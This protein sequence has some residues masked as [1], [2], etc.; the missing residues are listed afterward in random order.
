MLRG[1]RDNSHLV[2]PNLGPPTL[3][4]PIGQGDELLRACFE[5]AF[6]SEDGYEAY[7][8]FV[9]T[10]WL[11]RV[12]AETKLLLGQGD[13]QRW[14]ALIDSPAQ[15]AELEKRVELRFLPSARTRYAAGDRV[16]LVVE[17]K[18]VPTLLV[19]VFAVDA[20]RYLIDKQKPVDATIE[21]D[22]IVANHEQSYRYEDPAMRRVARTFPLPMLDKAGTYVVEFVGNGISSRAVIHKGE[23]R[24]VETPGAAGHVLRV[25]DESG[26]HRTD[27][28][29]WFGGREYR[30]DERGEIVLP[31]STSPGMKKVVLR[32]GDH[33]GLANFQHQAESY[34]LVASVHTAREALLAG[35]KARVLVRPQLRLGDQ[36][37][38]L[39]LLVDP[40]LT[41]VATDHDGVAT[42][43]E[44]RDLKLV[45]ERELVHEIQVPERLAS[46]AVSLRG[47]VKDLAGKD[48]LLATAAVS[49][50][51]NRIDATAETG[52]ALLLPKGDGYVV[53]L[54]GK[55]GE[56]QG[57]RP[58]TVQVHLRDYREPATFFLQ[59]SADGR[60]ELGSLP[61]A[62]A[63]TIQRP[64]ATGGH[65]ELPRTR[66]RFP[67][68]L[69][70]LAGQV[71]RVPYDGSSTA[72]SRAEFSLLGSERDEFAHLAI[73]DGFVELRDLAPGDYE[74][75]LH[76][77][78]VR[79]P[80]R[81]IR[82]A[83]SGPWLLGGTRQLTV[84]DA[85]P[86]QVRASA[87]DAGLEV[88][89]ANATAATRV[90]VVGTRQLPTFDP[91][92]QLLGDAGRPPS[93]VQDEPT[94]SSYYSG[95][96]LSEEYRYVLERRL[97][98]KFFGNMLARPS[99]LANPW[100][101]QDSSNAPVGIG[102]GAGGA[103]GARGGRGRASGSPGK[104]GSEA[105]FGGNPG[106]FANLDWL[107]QGAIVLANLVPGADGIVRVP[108]QELGDG[109]F[110]QVVALDRDQAVTT[111]VVRAEQPLQP[112]ARQLPKA[113]DPQQHFAE[114]KRI[115]FVTAGGTAKL[116]D[117][118]QAQV[119]I[120][121]SLA[122]VFRLF[123]TISRDAE[124]AK[125]GFLM[126]WPTLD[127]AQK[128]KLYDEHACHELH[129]F[130]FHKDAQFFAAV[131]KPLL[132]NKLDKTFVDHWLL[133]S[134]LRG[135]L[136]PWTFAQLNLVERVLLSKRL[137]GAE[138]ATIA[139]SLQEELELR[140]VDRERAGRLLDLA[141]RAN[142]LQDQA[143]DGLTSA[144]LKAPAEEPAAPP[145][146]APAAPAPVAAGP[147]GP[148]TGGQP[149]AKPEG[150]PADGKAK[151]DT[152]KS[153]EE[154]RQRFAEAEKQAPP[155]Y[156]V[157]SLG[158][159]GGETGTIALAR[160]AQA[161]QLYRAVAATKL[162]VES[163]WWHR[164]LEQTTADVVAPN[165]FWVDYATAPAGQPFASPRSDRNQHQLPRDDDGARRAR[166]AVRRRQARSHQP[167]ATRAR[168]KA[169]TPLLLVRKEIRR[170]RRLPTSRRC[171]SARTSS[172]ST[173]ATASRTA[174][175]A[176]PSS[177]T[178][179]SSTSPTAARS[180]SPTRPRATAP[181]TCCCRSRPGA[182]PLQK[183]FW[184]KGHTVELAPYATADP[185]V[186][187][188]LPG[189][190]RLRPL[191]GPRRR[192][193]QAR[194]Q[195]RAAHAARRRRADQGRHG[196]WEHVS[197]Q[198]TPPTCSPSSTRTTCSASSSPRSPGA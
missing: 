158:G 145:A 120:H 79:I 15:V 150:A 196:S 140:P 83:V 109:H 75:R 42:T 60:I 37:V 197:Q 185:R 184:T 162:L 52:T 34:Q 3:L 121:D 40:V 129:L 180:S 62:T 156:D 39:Q 32:A 186:R 84:G 77:S 11:K 89:V 155:G 178:S 148:V 2:D 127:Q 144:R 96:K 147:G 76:R 107:P 29:A 171:C 104:A 151:N 112:R 116:E 97:Q 41:V 99:L 61:G 44:V 38:P 31:F 141:L 176:M 90:V 173:T 26:A 58:C 81:V 146:M 72:P 50:A 160:R 21:L 115:E 64:D 70:G 101:V 188:L 92:A 195:R 122:S 133:G 66:V 24:L 45:D 80:V 4:E 13:P 6:A 125:F 124:L 53:E 68:A 71:L 69:H 86:L 153:A 95:R 164:R 91:F 136:E 16:E 175:G 194:R 98:A 17:T 28:V 35:G 5:H 30:A 47:T 193:G 7:A 20:F 87:N 85:T 1:V 43:Q 118:R 78:G 102:G 192:E 163:N 57:G 94:L 170:P 105:G 128:Q 93:A 63:V 154:L 25:H 100:A 110:L 88:R 65:Y 135:Y 157:F 106:E 46:L 51:C 126:Q 132:A 36:D 113:L 108:I 33:T 152:D 159:G 143:R 22:G 137:G 12:F 119:E 138:A 74:L 48:V 166:P 10:N 172:A 56:P 190:R 179:S 167:T 55:N 111:H 191:P 14:Y 134:D 139:R 54:R 131:V 130:L 187:V 181:P 59:T 177:P 142:E 123:T 182:M 168:C 18:N 189:C 27:A 73:S 174:S 8:E 23:L 183:G 67:A 82:G 161:Q 198:G 169:A 9:D 165:R 49:F 19:K 149:A 117:A 114:Q 103:Y